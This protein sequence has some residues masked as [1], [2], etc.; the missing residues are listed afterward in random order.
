M[1]A[2]KH[3]KEELKASRKEKSRLLQMRKGK[4]V[5]FWQN[6]AV[7]LNSDPAAEENYDKMKEE[8]ERT[9]FNA[10][11][12]LKQD[13]ERSMRA[14]EFQCSHEKKCFDRGLAAANAHIRALSGNSD[15]DIQ[16]V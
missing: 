10:M 11:Q 1:D 6:F 15:L 12:Q 13:F 4:F 9:H 2:L 3:V 7:Y 8:A 5:F 14:K 16:I